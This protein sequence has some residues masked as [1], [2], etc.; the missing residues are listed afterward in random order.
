MSLIGTETH[1]YSGYGQS[2]RAT[3]FVPENVGASKWTKMLWN[4][5]AEHQL[6]SAMHHDHISVLVL[7]RT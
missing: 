4:R 5:W 6:E 1:G 7:V 3:V 2:H